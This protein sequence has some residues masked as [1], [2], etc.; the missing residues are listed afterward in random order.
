MNEL[1]NPSEDTAK[2]AWVLTCLPGIG[3]GLWVFV[4]DFG[5]VAGFAR[6]TWVRLGFVVDRW[7]LWLIAGLAWDCWRKCNV[8]FG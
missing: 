2:F 3:W 5:V 4:A 1:T 8:F 6:L 7:A